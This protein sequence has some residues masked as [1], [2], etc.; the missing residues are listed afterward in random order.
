[1]A[2]GIAGAQEFAHPGML[3]KQS[4][5]DRMQAEVNAGAQPWLAGWQKLLANSHSSADYV[6]RPVDT[7]YRGADSP[8]TY[9]QNYAQLYNDV[10]AAYAL[11]LRWHISSDTTY[12]NASVNVL[13]AWSSRLKVISGTNDEYLAA[14]IYGYEIANAAELMR[15]Y[16]G[17]AA[18]DFA[19]FQ[20]MMLTIFYPMNHAFLTRSEPCMSHMYA[21][22]DLCNM[23]SMISIG[24]LCD[25][26]AIYNEAVDY[27]MHGAGNG[28]IDSAVWYLHPDGL[29]Q[30][31]ESGRDQGHATL[32]PALMGAF[33]EMAWNQ[34][35]D[36]YG[37]EDNRFLKGIEYVAKYNLGDSVP[38]VTYSNCTGVVQTVIS[39]D[40]R[41]T[42]R[43]EW[44]LLYNHYVNIKGL[45]APYT[46]LFAAQVRPEGGGGD[47]GPNSGGYDQL[48]YG[49]LTATVLP[50]TSILPKAPPGLSSSDQKFLQSPK[51]LWFDAVGK[52]LHPSINLRIESAEPVFPVYKN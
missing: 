12:A 28:N 42:I 22:W 10:A 8:A 43:P 23:A 5:L 44:E 16:S 35:D 33:C 17:W 9:T 31:Q 34:G 49:T 46:Q 20:N 38:Y 2:C 25:N 41:G 30:W 15:G 24:I 36:L 4:D 37:Y 48:G 26:R 14:G 29:G 40:G 51:T 11:A 3:H 50:A 21:N 18:A 6:P 13:N 7:V 39:P 52:K 19:R 27:F 32:G 47:Y 1:M 45:S